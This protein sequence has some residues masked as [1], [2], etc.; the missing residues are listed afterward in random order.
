MDIVLHNRLHYWVPL[1]LARVP[2]LEGG[3]SARHGEGA[4]SAYG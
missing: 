4:T 3:R 2:C 1:D